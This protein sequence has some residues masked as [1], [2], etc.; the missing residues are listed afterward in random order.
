VPNIRDTL[1]LILT[2]HAVDRLND[3]GRFPATP[4]LPFEK[5]VRLFHLRRSDT[6]E[7]VWMVQITGGFLIGLLRT[8]KRRQMLVAQTA[9]SREMFRRSQYLRLAC[10]RVMV[11]RVTQQGSPASKIRNPQR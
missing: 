11:D 1:E 6:R 10:H 4:D 3:P 9:I 7:V 8:T 2:S 5:E